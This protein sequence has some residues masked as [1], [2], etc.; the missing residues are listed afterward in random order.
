M[1]AAEHRA[2]VERLG[3][4]ANRIESI[5]DDTD[6]T[7]IGALVLQSI[8]ELA[9]ELAATVTE[10]DACFSVHE[11][12]VAELAR[13]LP[14]AEENVKTVF[15]VA[16][17]LAEGV[18]VKQINQAVAM[19]PVGLR[20]SEVVDRLEKAGLLRRVANHTNVTV[21]P[22]RQGGDVAEETGR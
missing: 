21:V 13:R 9:L 16:V 3:A 15:G 6:P 1:I 2:R 8:G 19:L 11:L 7:E 12:A 14:A 17:V 20:G 5:G 18:D 22:A 10:T 4:I